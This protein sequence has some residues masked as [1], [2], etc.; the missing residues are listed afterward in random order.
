MFQRGSK[1]QHK[2]LAITAPRIDTRAP[3]CPCCQG[4]N[5]RFQ[6]VD[7]IRQT[8]SFSCADCQHRWSVPKVMVQTNHPTID[9]ATAAAAAARQAEAR[10]EQ[11]ARENVPIWAIEFIRPV[12]FRTA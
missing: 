11:A 4:D 5:G 8:L 9:A 7:L 12:G 1:A 3:V 10:A 2:N 6:F